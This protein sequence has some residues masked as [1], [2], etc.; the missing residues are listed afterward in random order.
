MA[1][2]A[3]RTILAPVTLEPLPGMILMDLSLGVAMA[4]IDHL[5]GGPGGAQ[6]QR[7]PT[8]LELPLLR[9]LMDRMLAELKY[10]FEAIIPL[11]PS[12]GTLDYNPQ[13]VRAYAPSDAVV[14]ASFETRVGSEECIA[15][16]CMPFNMI[17]PVL[18]SPGEAVQLSAAEKEARRRAHL[19]LVGGLESIPLNVAVRF[20]PQRM[21]TEEVIDLQPGDIVPLNH[22]TTQ[23]LTIT[24]SGNTFAFAVPG[25][26][27]SRLACLVVPGP[28]EE[29]P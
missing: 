24:V 28:P 11:N 23:P 18:Q 1:T 5:L 2:L 19:N 9:G 13:F 20:K 25:N 14:V 29:K 26:Q 15:T 3:E 12:L 27:G 10:S 7:P 8:E 16:I 6:P 17:L 22:P 4:C 21:R